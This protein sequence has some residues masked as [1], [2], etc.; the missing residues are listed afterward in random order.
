MQHEGICRSVTR[1]KCMRACLHTHSWPSHSFVTASSECTSDAHPGRRV[2]LALWILSSASP[3]VSRTA[4][5]SCIAPL[6]KKKHVQIQKLGSVE[7]YIKKPWEQ[8]PGFICLCRK[9][10]KVW[11]CFTINSAADVGPSPKW[12]QRSYCVNRQACFS[13][14]HWPCEESNREREERR[15]DFI[16][17]DRANACLFFQ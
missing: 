9:Q 15:W 10:S 4:S 16:D 14:K 8:V 2:S 17:G 3:S 11:Q 1:S 7:H 6:R 5:H 12:Q 13:F